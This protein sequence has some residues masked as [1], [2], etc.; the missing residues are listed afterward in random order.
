MRKFENF[1]CDVREFMS[2]GLRAVVVRSSGGES[3]TLYCSYTKKKNKFS[4]LGMA[5]IN[6]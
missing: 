5:L 4:E 3:E 6:L 2:E 1:R